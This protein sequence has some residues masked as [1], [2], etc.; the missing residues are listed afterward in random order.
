MGLQSLNLD[1]IILINFFARHLKRLVKSC[2]AFEKTYLHSDFQLIS[3]SMVVF[4]TK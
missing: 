4:W 3:K 1:C 2:I